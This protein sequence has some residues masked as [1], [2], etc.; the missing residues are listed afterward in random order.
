MTAP[1]PEQDVFQK[2]VWCFMCP[3]PSCRLTEYGF[4]DCQ[5]ADNALREHLDECH[6]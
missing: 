5:D 4:E 6:D 3:A 2:Q 1:T